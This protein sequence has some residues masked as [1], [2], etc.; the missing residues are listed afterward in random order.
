MRT[1]HI[2]HPLSA[3]PVYSAGFLTDT[4]FVLG[5]G[6]GTGRSGIRNKLVRQD[7][8]L[9]WQLMRRE[10]IAVSLYVS[11]RVYDVENQGEKLAL[12]AEAE[13]EL[14]E[15]APMTMAVHPKV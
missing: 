5:G 11:Q 6:G 2:L 8:H 1:Q 9:H 3:F 14:G 7:I 12:V 4:R 13:L 15:D 10:S